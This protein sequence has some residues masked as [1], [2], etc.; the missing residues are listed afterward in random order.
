MS[1]FH[2]YVLGTTPSQLAVNIFNAAVDST[3]DV[4]PVSV[5]YSWTQ[6]NV[7]GG[8]IM[9]TI[10][11]VFASNGSVISNTSVNSSS[12]LTVEN[13]PSCVE[14]NGTLTATNTNDSTTGPATTTTYN[15][16]ESGELW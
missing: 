1:M 11:T 9:Y 10:V 13:L 6:L 5:N 12:T 3:T 14:L 16:S 4:A 2:S 7:S 8:V 15:T